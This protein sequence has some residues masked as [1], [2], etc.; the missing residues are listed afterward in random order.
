MALLTIGGFSERTRLSAKALRLYDELGLLAPA[1]VD[2][3]SGYR[4]YSEDQ[5][6][7]AR[8]V[9]MLRGLDMP[10]S[11]IAS[12]LSLDHAAAVAAITAYW[13]GVETMTAERRALAVYLIRRLEGK[14]Q[15]VY[16]INVRSI[17]ERKLLCISRHVHGDEVHDFFHEAFT[18]LRSVAPAG[19]GPAGAPF[20]IMYGETTAD[21]DGPVEL[22]LPVATE[23]DEA[24]IAGMGDIQLRTEP[25][26]DEAYIHHGVSDVSWPEMIDALMKWAT[27]HEREPAGALREIFTFVPGSPPTTEIDLAV[28]L[29]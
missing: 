17:P 15:R 27:E 12:V 18:R 9:G 13:Q 22:C 23:T 29:R 11:Q 10:L 16:E 19:A 3:S 25:S 26:H 28:P 21:S 1:R 5:V 24:A 4:L 20:L 7:R 8:L 14:D 2:P 6:E